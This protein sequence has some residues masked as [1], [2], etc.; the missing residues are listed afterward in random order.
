MDTTDEDFL[1]VAEVCRI[2]RKP[3]MFV[4][5][6]LNSGLLGFFKDS[7]SIPMKNVHQFL[8]YGTQW[9]GMENRFVQEPEAEPKYISSPLVHATKRID[10]NRPECAEVEESYWVAQFYLRKNNYYFPNSNK[11]SLAGGTGLSLRV[12]CPPKFGH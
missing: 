5:G 10:R 9:T 1:S 6:L 4:A 8:K 2:L 3:Q 11:I 12:S 7:Q